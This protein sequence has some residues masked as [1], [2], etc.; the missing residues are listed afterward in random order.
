MKSATSSELSVDVT[1]ADI[2]AGQRANVYHSPVARAI[3]RAFETPYVAVRRGPSAPASLESRSL[4]GALKANTT[5]FA[6]IGEQDL[7]LPRRAQIF[8]SVWEHG[9]SGGAAF[10]IRSTD[11]QIVA[12]RTFCEIIRPF[13]FRL[14]TLQS[15]K[16]LT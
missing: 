14:E 3:A 8:C 1:D 16:H 11:G 2:A 7:P 6:V 10:A 9:Q 13:I 5:W 4:P 15:P 12:R